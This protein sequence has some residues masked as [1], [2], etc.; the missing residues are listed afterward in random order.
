MTHLK[1]GNPDVH[2]HFEKSTVTFPSLEP[3]F[4]VHNFS[5]DLSSICLILYT[6]WCLNCF[7]IHIRLLL[8]LRV[9]HVLPNLI[10]T[11]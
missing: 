4:S 5:P 6:C 2:R 11:R 8:L 7:T 3:V 1:I 9:L 10:S